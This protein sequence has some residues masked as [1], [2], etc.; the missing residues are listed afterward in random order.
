MIS[1]N[2]KIDK[3]HNY[4]LVLDVETANDLEDALVYDC[5]FAVC[6]TR[7]NVY[8]TYSF[9]VSDI[10]IGEKE[11]MNSA[12]YANKIPN[13]WKDIWANDRKVITFAQLKAF[14]REIMEKYNT[15]VVCAHNARFDANAL[16][17]TERY[18]TKSKYRYFFPY[19]TEIWDS[20]MMARS[21]IGNMPTYK[22]Y[23]AE[24]GYM[25]KNNQ[26]RFTAEIL[27]RFITKNEKFIEAHT[28]LEDVMIEKEIVNYCYRQHKPM[29]KVLYERNENRA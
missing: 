9:V 25:T 24:N 10:F 23:C 3:R 2:Y 12:Y 6:D 17:I 1:N 20:L 19:G 18:L 13:Y 28:A 15:H 8:E 16:N 11:L 27:Y 7:G 26:C 14:I 21:V 4:K 22:K 5:G 29:K